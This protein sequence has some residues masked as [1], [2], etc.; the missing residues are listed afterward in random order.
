MLSSLSVLGGAGMLLMV[1]RDEL[2][3][4]VSTTSSFLSFWFEVCSRDSA[5]AGSL[6]RVLSYNNESEN[7]ENTRSHFDF[8][9]F[10]A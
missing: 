6:K 2:E 10:I 3:R 5:F 9:R 8:L 7:N 1:S 4:G